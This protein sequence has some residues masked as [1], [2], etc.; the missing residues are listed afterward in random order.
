MKKK[1]SV[2]I[3]D[4]HH[5]FRK[6]ILSILKN[7]DPFE[8]VGEAPDGT[9]A[10]EKIRRLKPDIALLDLDMPGLNGL[11]IA[12]IISKEKLPVK[13]AILTMHKEK[14][15]FNK[16]MEIHVKAFLLKDKISDDLI[17]C[18]KTVADN[19]YFIS[20]QLSTFL[21][22]KEKPEW[23]ELLTSAELIVL[24]LLAKNKTSKQISEELFNSVRT[25]ENHRNNICKKLNLSG[26]N[27]LLLFASKNK[28]YLS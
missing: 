27:A 24:R 25:I 17:E 6:G 4:D 3:A 18:L 7:E 11:E 2:L 19:K 23:V 9:I 15:Y 21:V 5:I 16:A 14:E 10:I 26:Q 1:I 13:V 22:D 12:M 28:H 20:P 8:V